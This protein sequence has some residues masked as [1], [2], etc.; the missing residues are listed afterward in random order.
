MDLSDHFSLQFLATV[1]SLPGGAQLQNSNKFPSY[2]KFVKK[3][4]GNVKL[5]M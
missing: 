2:S 1:P 3:P 4:H 5:S